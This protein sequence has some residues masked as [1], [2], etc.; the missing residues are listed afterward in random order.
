VLPGYARLWRIV[1]ALTKAHKAIV[2]R[3][4][5]RLEIV[6]EPQEV[7]TLVSGGSIVIERNAWPDGTAKSFA[8]FVCRGLK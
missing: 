5:G 1:L 3:H 8:I 6:S 4:A 2:E 7:R